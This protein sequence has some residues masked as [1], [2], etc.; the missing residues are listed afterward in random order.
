[1]AVGW[2]WFIARRTPS[3][4]AW[5]RL[6]AVFAESGRE[7]DKNWNNLYSDLEYQ[8]ILAGIKR[9]WERYRKEFSWGLRLVRQLLPSEDFKTALCGSFIMN[10]LIFRTC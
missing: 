5:S 1:V 6:F 4:A 9:H 7:R 3:S 8:R 10:D 2:A